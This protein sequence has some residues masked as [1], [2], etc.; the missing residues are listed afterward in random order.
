VAHDPVDLRDGDRAHP[1]RCDAPSVARLIVR[2]VAVAFVVSVALGTTAACS[3]S[4][5]PPVE[6]APTRT[7]APFDGP[8]GLELESEGA[9]RSVVAEQQRLVAEAEAA[10]LAAEAAELAR[11]AA[12]AEAAKRERLREAAAAADAAE[13][14]DQGAADDYVG[15]DR[16]F[17]CSEGTATVEECFG[18]GSD[19]N[20]NGIA[21]VNE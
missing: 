7:V 3:S 6:S 16:E 5:P 21:D 9:A 2:R 12:E 15:D 18:P 4:D 20:G 13:Q 10:R 19:L 17:R 11:L 8:S 14:Q 1:L